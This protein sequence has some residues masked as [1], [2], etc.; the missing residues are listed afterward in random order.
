[1]N[2]IVKPTQAQVD[3]IS[4]VNNQFQANGSVASRLLSNGMDPSSLRTNTVLQKDEWKQLDQVVIET[5]RDRMRGV[6]D[7]VN[8]GLT[9]DI[10]NAMGTTVFEW[11]DMSDMTPAEL[12]M[13]GVTR[14][15]GDRVT[16]DLNQ[17]PLPII[18]KEFHINARVL[19]ASRSR[20]QPLDTTQAA[21]ASRLVSE[22][23]E[24][25][26][27]NGSS[28]FA[29]GGGTLY[30]YRDFPSRQTY[31]ITTAWDASAKT[32]E[33][34]LADVQ[35]M[36]NLLCAQRHFGPYIMYVS[37][38]FESV[39]DEDFKAN[40]DRTIRERLLALSVIQDIRVSDAMPDNQ[41]LLVQMERSTVVMLM[42]MQNTLVEWSSGDNMQ[43]HFR[44]MAIMV[45]RFAADH[46]GQTGICHGSV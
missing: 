22:K 29:F 33:G 42:G 25:I 18:H 27:F 20:G 34:I 11:E 45:P 12:D 35:A 15:E 24:D 40:S 17:V 26:L 28:S 3:T 46:L 5:A 8:A 23:I 10:P 43:S 41:V 6:A 39:L 9:I 4:A 31:T 38:N 30:G 16:F 19:A 1:M 32:G 13:A 44:V 7:L 21:I 2:A 37:K 36:R 14:G